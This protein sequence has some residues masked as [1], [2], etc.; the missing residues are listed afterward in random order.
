MNMTQR[1]K[2]VVG[3]WKMHGSQASAT[4]LLTAINAGLRSVEA[5]LAVC[6]PFPYLDLVE[7]LVRDSPVALGAQNVSEHAQGAFT[8]EVCAAM[9]QD[10]GCKFVLVGHSERR[11]LCHETDAM[12]AEKARAAQQ[13]GLI[14]IICVGET[15]EERDAG[16]TAPVVLRQIDAVM[17][18]LAGSARGS[19]V[20]AY[21]P[22]WAIGTGRT[23]TPEQ[24]QAV[25]AEIRGRIAAV[26][27]FAANATRILYGG[28]V[29]PATA[30]QLFSQRDID[31]ALV[32]GASLIASDFV[33][34]AAAANIHPTRKD[35]S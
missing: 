18:L 31:G 15:L 3:N 19:C 22:V 17:H 33:A 1:T 11:T 28:S 13:H 16:R 24:A 21:E 27:S 4:A 12:V 9:L 2:L 26:D 25:H 32:G 23:A 10:M 5:D 6:V 29:K 20:V 7:R 30:A 14:P 35:L 34:I 8:G